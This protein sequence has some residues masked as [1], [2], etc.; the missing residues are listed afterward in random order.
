MKRQTL[1][2]RILRHY[3]YQIHYYELARMV[4]PQA[5]YPKAWEYSKNGGPPGLVMS[6]SRAI[7]ELGG[8]V[9]AQKKVFIPSS[10]KNESDKD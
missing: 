4:Y 1:K 9:D 5:E 6:F 10:K 7:R 2:D 3:V 8:F